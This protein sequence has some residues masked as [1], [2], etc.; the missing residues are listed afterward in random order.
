MDIMSYLNPR[1]DIITLLEVA[2]EE[3]TEIFEELD[4]YTKKDADKAVLTY[5]ELKENLS[6]YLHAADAVVYEKMRKVDELESDALRAAQEHA[7]M[8]ELTRKL[9][10]IDPTNVE[11][12]LGVL[13][14]LEE[15]VKHH[16]ENER[17]YVIPKLR[18]RFSSGLREAMGSDF[19]KRQSEILRGYPVQPSTVPTHPDLMMQ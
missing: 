8:D 7:L 9:D 18:K 13:K 12:W 14:S 3:I 17:R 4:G 15:V 1:Y 5:A 10:A 2:H 11:L 19:A 16:L 6:S